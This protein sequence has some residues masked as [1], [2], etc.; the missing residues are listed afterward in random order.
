MIDTEYLKQLDRFNLMMKKRVNTRYQGSRASRNVGAGL[1]FEDY[2][3]YVPGDDFRK[4]DW[5]V[6]G[7]TDKFFIRRY[8]EER[9][10]T[11]HVVLDASASM[12]FGTNN[13]TKFEFG[14][15]LGIGFAY[16]AMHNNEKFE[17]STFSKNLD[18]FKPRKGLNQLIGIIE[19]LN[20]TKPVGNTN[21]HTSVMQYKSVVRTKSMVVFISD[22]LFPIPEIRE[23]LLRFKKSE[24]VVIQV[25]DPVERE[26]DL[27][28]DMI[29]K[30]AE[31]QDKMRT[32]VSN[33]LKQE[34]R[35]RLKE[36]VNAIAEVCDNMGAPFLSVG[37]DTQVFDAFYRILSGDTDKKS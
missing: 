34:Y 8:E 14:A 29:L 15:K 4:I 17:F 32:F 37:T 7:R 26:F 30:D 13:T 33:R 35:T 6:Y 27:Q 5:K 22:F 12:D 21:F 20:K 11:V 16:M 36:H 31:S 1:T 24:V 3:E 10:L 2:K 19:H 23:T 28:G 18:I 9:N 25:L